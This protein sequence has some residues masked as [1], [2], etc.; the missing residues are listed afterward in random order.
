MT[1]AYCFSLDSFQ[2][3]AYTVPCKRVPMGRALHKSTKEKGMGALSSVSV[4]NHER[5]CL[6][7]LNALEANNWRN[8]SIQWNQQWL[9]G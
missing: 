5:V 4:F 2:N 6:K 7:G 3:S 1:S 8:S 9:R